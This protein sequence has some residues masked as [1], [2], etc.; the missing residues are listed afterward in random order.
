MDVEDRYV[1]FGPTVNG[2]K[3]LTYENALTQ[4]IKEKKPGYQA[5]KDGIRLAL[6]AAGN[7]GQYIR[8]ANMKIEKHQEQINHIKELHDKFDREIQSL[9]SQNL[10]KINLDNNKEAL[11]DV[12]VI[13]KTLDQL[14]LGKRMTKTKL[15]T[16]E[17]QL[18]IAEKEL[19]LQERQIEDVRE[20]LLKTHFEGINVLEKENEI[21]TL[22]IIKK[23]LQNLG[24]DNDIGKL[25]NAIDTLASSKE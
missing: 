6:D 17:S 10:E 23:E 21:S 13:T 1:T 14:L 20:N 25:S 22:N 19:E 12:K 8:Y 11:F 5:A 2:L 18:G 7:A 9:Q 16:L 15:R 3:N 4:R 24:K